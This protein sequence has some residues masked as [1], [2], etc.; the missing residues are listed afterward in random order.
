MKLSLLLQGGSW[1][2]VEEFGKEKFVN[3]IID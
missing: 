2:I 1:A 3:L